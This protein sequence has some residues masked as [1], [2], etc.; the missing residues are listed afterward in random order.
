ML[1][2]ESFSADLPSYMASQRTMMKLGTIAASDTI[3][4][5][6]TREALR[7]DIIQPQQLS[8]PQVG[9]VYV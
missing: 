1:S 4:W 9:T 5:L 7:F 6:Q 3:L 2:P 8:T